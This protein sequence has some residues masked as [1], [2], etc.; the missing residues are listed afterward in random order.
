M[1]R[2]V[3]RTEAVVWVEADAPCEVEVL[4]HAQRTFRVRG[5]HF[6]V[7]AVRGLEP[8]TTTPYE[9][10]LDG[11]RVWPEEGSAFPP[12]T[13]RTLGGHRVRLVVA[14]CR[15]AAPHVPPW[16]DSP[17]RDAKHGRDR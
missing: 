17:D 7:V 14:S 9:V 13:I 4:G 5:H 1:L 12:S 6:G 15:T 8:G 16:A 3:S 2:Y 11:E 10:R